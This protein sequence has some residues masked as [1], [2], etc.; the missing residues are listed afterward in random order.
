MQLEFSRRGRLIGQT[1]R[2]FESCLL[3]PPMPA[4]L[5]TNAERLKKQESLGC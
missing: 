1:D 4:S 2:P 3:F 5:D